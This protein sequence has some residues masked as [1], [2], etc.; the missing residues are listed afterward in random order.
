MTT[1]YNVT[2]NQQ[3]K[4][5][6]SHESVA[7]LD[8]ITVNKNTVHLLF[9]NQSYHVELIEKDYNAK[10]YTLKVQGAIY[11]VKIANALDQLIEQMGL[12]TA[13]S[14]KINQIKAPMPG[15]ILDISI[16]VG[17][18]VKENDT[19]L[20]L[21][22]MKMENSITSPRDGIIKTIAVKKGAAVDKNQLLIEFE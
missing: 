21:E 13:S 1:N 5:Q 2:I 8:V 7:D 17:D 14:K 16:K 4:Q 18:E 3:I 20:I 22:A 6:I 15:L 11:T 12:S 9:N 19:L 10:T